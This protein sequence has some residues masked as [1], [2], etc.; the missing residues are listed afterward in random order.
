MEV[1]DNFLPDAAHQRFFRLIKSN[2]FPW[3]LSEVLE[4]EYHPIECSEDDN[5]Q[6]SYIFCSSRDGVLRKGRFFEDAFPFF[7]KLVPRNVLMIKANLT[8]RTDKIIEHGMHV[9]H[10]FH[11]KTAVYYVN[12]NDGY[13][14]FETGEVVESVANRIVIF[15][16]DIKHTGTTCT[17]ALGRFVVNLNYWQ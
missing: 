6:F 4:T 15:D 2:T 7:Q 13:T 3:F 1:I 10:H 5:Y 16:S 12:S 11:S 8:L 9:D 14:K 17:N